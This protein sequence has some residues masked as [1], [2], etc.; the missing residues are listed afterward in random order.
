[1][2]PSSHEEQQ[3]LTPSSQEEEEEQRQHQP[4]QKK[5]RLQKNNQKLPKSGNEQL[6]LWYKETCH[7][8]RISKKIKAIFRTLGFI[9]SH[10]DEMPKLL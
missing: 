1:M 8:T 3:K 6:P 4:Q 2:L 9:R 5:Q 10:I 7:K